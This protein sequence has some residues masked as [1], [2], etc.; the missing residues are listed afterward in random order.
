M[1]LTTKKGTISNLSEGTVTTGRNGNTNSQHSSAFR[2]DNFPAKLKSGDHNSLSNGD[3]ITAVGEIKKGSLVIY[4]YR[5]DTTGAYDEA[6]TTIPLIFGIGL[7]IIGIPLSFM[8]IGLPLL[9]IGGIMLYGVYLGYQAK[10]ILR[11]S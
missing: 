4:A 11:Q 3:V 10:N 6:Q 5:N 9:V 8:I 1:A 2:I 7:L